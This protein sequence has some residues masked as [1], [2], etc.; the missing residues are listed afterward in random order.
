M[1]KL[2][3]TDGN[4]TWIRS[5][6]YTPGRSTSTS[7]LYG[8][9]VVS[10]WASQPYRHCL[11]C[12]YSQYLHAPSEQ[13]RQHELLVALA[14]SQLPVHSAVH[15]PI[16][17][18]LVTPDHSRL[19]HV[20]HDS[21]LESLGWSYMSTLVF[22]VHFVFTRGNHFPV[23]QPSSNRSRPSTLNLGVLF[24]WVSRK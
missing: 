2:R 19:G 15:F 22:F 14:Q 12:W 23:C 9:Q 11:P 5:T 6:T 16:E 7:Y 1:P 4:I 24:R 3:V 8:M 13:S 20:T 18:A 21:S 17:S 10:H